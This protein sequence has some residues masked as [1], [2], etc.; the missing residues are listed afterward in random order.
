MS[1]RKLLLI[2]GGGHCF[3]VLDSVLAS[4]RFMQIGIVERD[5]IEGFSDAPIVGHD[6]D[7][8]ELHEKGW[9]CA[10]ITIGSVGD[11]SSR[12]RLFN[13]IRKL[14]FAVPCI[15]DPSA[16]I[17][18][19]AKIGEGV[20]VGKNAVINS[21][22]VIEN[23]AIINSSSV[24]EHNCY[25]GEFSHVSSGAILCGNVTVGNDAHIGAGSVV[26]QQLII[27]KNSMIGIGSVVTKNIPD[28]VIAYGN[29]CKVIK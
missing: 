23:C 10:F 6:E 11:T 7:L 19:N 25:I 29:P 18:N 16:M 8:T 20:Y 1:D 27:G 9:N 12:H 17:A 13:L 15:V 14:G 2:G 4:K 22:A 24:V 21:M 3:S 28:G 26:R 5:G